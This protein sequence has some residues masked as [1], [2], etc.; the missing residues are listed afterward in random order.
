MRTRYIVTY[1]IR[2]AKRLREVY[3]TMRGWGD[4]L[5]YSVFRCDLSDR[6]RMEMLAALDTI[7]DHKE[8]QVLVIDLGPPD[9]RAATCITSLGRPYIQPERHAVIV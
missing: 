2:E 9:G 8:D 1:D 4:H 7:L 3:K 5:Q 6:E